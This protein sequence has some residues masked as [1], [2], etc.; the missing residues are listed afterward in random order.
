MSDVKKTMLIQ[1]AKLQTEA[2]MRLA[3]WMRAA[4]S[5]MAL[6]VLMGVWGFAVEWNPVEGV[7]GILVAAVAGSAAFLIHTGRKNGKRNV[8]KILKA[9]AD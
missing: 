7:C 4:L 6:G 1:E 3:V 5:L 2:L 9:A 8:E